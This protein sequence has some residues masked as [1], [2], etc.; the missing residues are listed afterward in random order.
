MLAK[1]NHK[2]QVSKIKKTLALV[3]VD[4]AIPIL[5]VD[6][7]G[8]D[9]VITAITDKGAFAE[10]ATFDPLTNT[11]HWDASLAQIGKH[12]AQFQVTDGTVTR[13]FK[14]PIKVVSSILGF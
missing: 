4:I 6:R 14:V 10:G 12:K 2:P 8:D 1:K 13:K 11:L 3:G 7:D 9:L 5:V